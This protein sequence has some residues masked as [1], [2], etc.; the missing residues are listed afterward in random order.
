MHALDERELLALL[1]DYPGSRLV[2]AIDDGAAGPGWSS[3]RW[4]VVRDQTD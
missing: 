2:A 1:P 3:R 4:Y